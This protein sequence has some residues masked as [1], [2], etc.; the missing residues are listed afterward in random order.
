MHQC[1]RMMFEFGHGHW[2]CEEDIRTCVLRY[3]TQPD[4]GVLGQQHN[5]LAHIASAQMANDFWAL[6]IRRTI[7]DDNHIEFVALGQR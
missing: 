3:T 5:R 2:L 1:V 6:K 4:A 7:V